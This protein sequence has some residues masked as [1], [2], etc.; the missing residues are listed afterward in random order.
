[1]SRWH[2]SFVENMQKSLNGIVAVRFPMELSKF[3]GDSISVGTLVL[4]HCLYVCFVSSRRCWPKK[5]LF[6]KLIL[7]VMQCAELNIWRLEQMK[8]FMWWFSLKQQCTAGWLSNEN[9]LRAYIW[10]PIVLPLVCSTNIDF[11]SLHKQ[12]I[13]KISHPSQS[14]VAPIHLQIFFPIRKKL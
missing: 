13:I 10:T 7:Y 9:L 11:P 8:V 5:N 4:K 14:C 12:I 1:M 2:L 3:V 6:L